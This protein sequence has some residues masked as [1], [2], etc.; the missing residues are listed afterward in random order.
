[1]KRLP[2]QEKIR[3][4]IKTIAKYYKNFKS[5][6]YFETATKYIKLIYPQIEY[7]KIK[8]EFF[9]NGEVVLWIRDEEIF[10]TLENTE[11]KIS[12]IYTKLS[13]NR[14]GNIYKDLGYMAEKDCYVDK[15]FWYLGK[16]YAQI[17]LFISEKIF[18][19]NVF[20]CEISKFKRKIKKIKEKELLERKKIDNK[21]LNQLKFEE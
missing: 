14:N 21:L 12:E 11:K 8:I 15:K 2:K 16:L 19:C 5:S 1:M 20:K 13:S 17:D 10:L 6:E 3:H 18:L 4:K 9:E 7:P